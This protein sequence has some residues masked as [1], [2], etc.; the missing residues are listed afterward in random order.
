ML[1]SIKSVGHWA[2]R[3]KLYILLSVVLSHLRATKTW[4]KISQRVGSGEWSGAYLFEEEGRVEAG[5][6]ADYYD[7]K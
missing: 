5:G 6:A 4:R 3:G 2:S 1:L 7:D